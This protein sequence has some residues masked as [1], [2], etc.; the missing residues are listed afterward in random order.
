MIQGRTSVEFLG[1]SVLAACL[2]LFSPSAKAES[3]RARHWAFQP[4]SEARLPEVRRRGWCQTSVDR[5]VLAKLEENARSPAPRADSRVLV[6]RITLDLIG[7]PPTPGE[8][9]AFV[10]SA[11]RDRRAAVRELIERLLASPQ[12]GERWGRWWLDVARYADTNG[13]DENKVMG[14]AWRYRDWVVRAFN[15]NLPFNRFITEQLAGDL[16]PPASTESETFDQ[17]VA[18]GFLVLG[19]KMLA[20]QDKPKLVMDI[21]DEQIDTVGRAF[22]GLTL[23][24]ARCHDHKFDPI[25]ATD[26]YAMAGIFKST[27]TMED[28]AFVSKF[29]ERP[30]ATRGELA[31]IEAHNRR[32]LEQTNRIDAVIRGA[33]AELLAGW[34]RDFPGY[35]A[36]ASSPSSA[37]ISSGLASNLVHRLRALLEPDPATNALSR[38]L[39]GIAAAPESAAGLLNALRGSGTLPETDLGALPSPRAAVA[40]AELGPAREALVGTNGIFVLP[41]DP[42]PFHAPAAREAL[43]ALE[44][45]LEALLRSAPPKASR[46]LAVAEDQP[47]D[48]PVHLRGSHLSLAK[49]P[50]PRGFVQVLANPGAGSKI[51]PDRSGRLEL[52][53]WLTDPAN[54]LTARVVVNRIWQAHFA[55]GLVR[56]P[57]NFG[58]RGA[59]P[60]HPEL[61]DWLAT[62]FIQSGWDVKALHRLILNSAAYQQSSVPREA[63]HP[64]NQDPEN[65][66]LSHFPRRRLDAEMIRDALL[67]VSGQLDPAMGGSLVAWANNEYVPRDEVS[68]KSR[69]RTLYLPI[70]RDRVFDVLTIFDFANPSVCTARRI[71][72]VASHQALFFLNSPL[73]KD[74]AMDI[75][76]SV[77]SRADLDEAGRIR[78]AYRRILSRRATSAE[79][80]RALRFIKELPPEAG[81]EKAEHERRCANFG[82]F[83]HTLLASN[84]FAYQF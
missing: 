65:L 73:V 81:P 25:P 10:Q 56:T 34:D 11:R 17:L 48:L 19:P 39:R 31:A 8:V 50:V 9:D 62:V 55:E 28:L 58:V 7:L 47:T 74:A 68:A 61:L 32:L 80:L 42:R 16:L 15:R 54:P 1:A 4:V 38:S 53:R 76:K 43:A 29:N 63:A 40:R 67:E 30:V 79:V 14:N 23:G 26:Y 77:L 51:P 45:E 22:L 20:E 70:V 75:A 21:V 36:A 83:C 24:C 35:L 27:R 2:I 82:A 13:Q 5:F 57:E 46:A 33:N 64:R 3:S 69:R 37:P 49:D 60:T 72:T 18:T 6:R 41:K 52:A 44:K 78:E 66:L 59:P 84:E 12:Y 71:P